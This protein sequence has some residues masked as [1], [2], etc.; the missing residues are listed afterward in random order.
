MNLQSADELQPFD[1]VLFG[2]T[3]DLSMRKLLPALYFRHCEGQLPEHGRIFGLARSDLDTPEFLQRMEDEA[4]PHINEK[5][6]NEAHWKMF[7][8]RITYL[9]L[10]ATAPEDY[11]LLANELSG[12][13]NRVR[14]CLLY[15]S[16]SPR[17]ATL[18]RMPSSA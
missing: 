15:T 7:L 12:H 16:P 3:G 5:E 8:S 10:D 9:R 13:E 4:R 1:F 18:S 11:Q 2:A 14:V 17:D 6:F